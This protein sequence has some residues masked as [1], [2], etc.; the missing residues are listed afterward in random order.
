MVLT[1]A[2]G[3]SPTGW[4]LGV[5]RSGKKETV[6]EARNRAA[7][8]TQTQ[9][10]PETAISGDIISGAP[11]KLWPS[12]LVFRITQVIISIPIKLFCFR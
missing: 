9:S 7:A 10:L 12:L 2:Q 11:F 4:L 8:E 5:P 6:K 1:T 3:C